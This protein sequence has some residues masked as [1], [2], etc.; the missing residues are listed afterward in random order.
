M[1]ECLS[2]DYKMP[3]AAQQAQQEKMTA[4]NKEAAAKKLEGDARKAFMSD[5]LSAE[6]KPSPAQ[7]AQQERMTACN[8]QASDKGLK[9]DERQKFMSTCLK[10]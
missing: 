6:G 1:S 10:G 9:G 5:C 4:C 3:S 7:K 2:A 8:K